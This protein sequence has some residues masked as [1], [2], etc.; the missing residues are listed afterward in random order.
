MDQVRLNP[1]ICQRN[2][3]LHTLKPHAITSELMIL[4]FR[5]YQISSKTVQ[6]QFS[7][8]HWF[9]TQKEGKTSSVCSFA[10]PLSPPKQDAQTNRPWHLSNS[11]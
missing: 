1:L 8:D 11:T 6:V 7:T 4:E 5:K 2:H 10:F 3:V 9:L